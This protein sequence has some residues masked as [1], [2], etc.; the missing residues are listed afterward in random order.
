MHK[1]FPN[2]A[3][4]GKKRFTLRLRGLDHIPTSDCSTNQKLTKIND[5][6]PAACKGGILKPVE[7]TVI[8]KVQIF[9]VYPSKTCNFSINW[10]HYIKSFTKKKLVYTF[11][12]F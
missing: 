8:G 7:G 9:L 1:D 3:E 10:L 12:L 5:S 4:R 11:L 6:G 2:S